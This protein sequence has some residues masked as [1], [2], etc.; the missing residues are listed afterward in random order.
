M[1]W[2]C[3]PHYRPFV[4]GIHRSP[5]DSPHKW[6]ITRSVVVILNKLL[7]KQLSCRWFE[8]K[9]C[10]CDVTVMWYISS[11][12]SPRNKHIKYQCHCW[13][14]IWFKHLINISFYKKCTYYL[15]VT[16]LLKTWNWQAFRPHA[17]ENFRCTCVYTISTC[18]SF[19]CRRNNDVCQHICSPKYLYIDLRLHRFSRKYIS[20]LYSVIQVVGI[21]IQYIL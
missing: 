5:I 6:P 12:D 13:C 18:I 3:P 19:S 14:S 11:P 1:I 15:S 7:N 17:S 10:L 8:T 9:Q 16:L 20:V 21:H 2:K 4:M